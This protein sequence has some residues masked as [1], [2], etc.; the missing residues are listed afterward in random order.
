MKI[1]TV[2]HPNE[3]YRTFNVTKLVCT[4]WNYRSPFWPGTKFE[5]V[6]DFGQDIV[7]QIHRIDGVQ[8]LGLDKYSFSVQKAEAFDWRDIELRLV[9]AIMETAN[10]FWPTEDIHTSI[11]DER[12]NCQE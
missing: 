1:V 2:Y 7:S 11:K 9:N 3:S 4:K 6:T 10:Q 12:R 5:G 8:E